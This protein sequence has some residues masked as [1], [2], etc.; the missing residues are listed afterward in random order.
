MEVRQF[1]KRL[2]NELR[3]FTRISIG[4][5]SRSSKSTCSLSHCLLL[6][7]GDS[8]RVGLIWGR[9]DKLGTFQGFCC[10]KR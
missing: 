5:L 6:D 8:M 10:L 2:C 1:R 7:K 9:L 3:N 4:L